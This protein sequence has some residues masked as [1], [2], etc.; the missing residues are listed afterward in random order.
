MHPLIRLVTILLTVGVVAGSAMAQPAATIE[1]PRIVSVGGALTEIIYALGA[2]KQLVAVDTT[3]LFP[4]A[5]Q[6]LPKVG[7]MRQLSAEGVLSMRPTL[8]LATSEAGPPNVLTQ[9]REAKVNLEIVSADHSIAELRNK[10]RAV[11]KAVGKESEGIVLVQKIVRDLDAATTWVTQKNTKPRVLFILS[12]SG[13]PQ[14]SGSDTAAD[15]VIKL[16]GGVNVM[17]G[18]KGYKP[19]TIEAAIGAVPDVILTT[20]QGLTAI[21]GVEKMLA[22]PGLA[23]TPAGKSRRVV[24]LDALYLL[25]FGPRL[26]QA[27]RET[28][29]RIRADRVAVTSR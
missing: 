7:Y 26:P 27:V 1:A 20:T 8:V 3:S 6:R 25:G 13:S 2:E 10:V 18:F 29:E 5:A 11:S 23:L 19:L 12:H 16:A 24:D 28:A 21:G 4:E 17:S 14:V 9:F 15:A 22:Q